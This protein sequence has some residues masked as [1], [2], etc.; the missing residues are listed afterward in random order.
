MDQDFHFHGTYYAARTGGFGKDDAT[1]IAKAANFIDF[2]TETTYAAYWKL[3]RG[4]DKNA[5]V[6][7]M[8]NPRYT[9]QGGIFGSGIIPEDGLWCSYHFTPGNYDDP[10]GTPSREAIHGASVAGSLPPFQKRRTDGGRAILQEYTYYKRYLPDLQYGRL[11]NRPQSALS[12]QLIQDAVRCAT[13]DARL[14]AILG[15]ASGGSEI[16]GPNREDNLRRFRLILLGVRAHVVADTWAHQDFCGLN[17]VMNTY[18]DVNYDPTSW[19]PSKLGYGRQ[20]IDYDDGTGSGWRNQ[21]LSWGEST[22]SQLSPN[23][24]AVPNGTSYL[25]HGWMGHLPDFS[26]VKFRYKPCWSDPAA[27]VERD[28]PR[29]YESAWLELTSLFHQA[30][31]NGHLDATNAQF[32][33]AQRKAST[34]IRTPC[35]IDSRTT[36]RSSSAQ[37]WQSLF[38]DLPSTNI[39]AD[40]EPDPHA[41]LDGMVEATTHIDRYGTDY[42]R[43]D[44]D[45]YLFQI[46]ADYHFH[47]VRWYLQRHG[48][49]RFA[50]PWSQQVSAL[51]LDVERLFTEQPL[52]VSVRKSARAGVDRDRSFDDV[53]SSAGGIRVLT[54]VV[55]RAG[56]VIDG[57]AVRYGD[58]TLSHGGTGGAETVVPLTPDDPITGV[59]G[60]TGEW[61]S[62]TRVLTLTLTTRS[63]QSWTFGSVAGSSN[64]VPFDF[65]ASAGE[66]IVGF[67]GSVTNVNGALTLGSIG[68]GI[69]SRH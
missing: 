67:F 34:A 57:L 36:G 30:L 59:S 21:V 42:V 44:S 29:E 62:A 53:P 69:A 31:G 64:Q 66:S 14:E 48:L 65:K 43:V 61:M 1:L 22:F 32:Q 26:F 55:V 17:N 37:A 47:F 3:V 56:E 49:Y 20:S 45:L 23:F 25:G 19:N 24:E 6:A 52:A 28:N 27:A 10:A 4:Q 51:S 12:R 15:C 68:V 50:G 38:G 41:V 54:Q 9:F 46:A 40:A 35:R 7:Q 13:D 16:L 39:D 8:D 60:H 5:V 18:W 33:L 2:F 11:L 63:G 58:Q